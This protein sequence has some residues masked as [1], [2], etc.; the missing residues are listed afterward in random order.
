MGIVSA[1]TFVLLLLII[2]AVIM[3]RTIYRDI[4]AA[5]RDYEEYMT[6]EHRDE[7]SGWKLVHADVFRKPQSFM[8]F[9]VIIGWGMQLVV[10]ILCTIILGF[11]NQSSHV[12]LTT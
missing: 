9:S 1:F 8:A 10:A 7:E 11:F 4:A 2:I 6:E 3:I 5:N 12:M